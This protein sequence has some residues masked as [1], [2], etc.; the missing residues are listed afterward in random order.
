MSPVSRFRPFIRLST[1]WLVVALTC[2]APVAAQPAGGPDEAT[3]AEARRLGYEGLSAFDARRWAEAY[4]RF[5]AAE[6]L[7]HSPVFVLYMARAKL[8][9]GDLIEASRLLSSVERAGSR[10][11]D[12][13]WQRAREDA[14]REQEALERRVPKL[15]V[16][17]DGEVGEHELQ[18]DGAAAK[19]GATLRL[20]PGKHTVTLQVGDTR[21]VETVELV[22]AE[23]TR[24]LTLKLFQGSSPP[25]PAGET[26]PGPLAG[27]QRGSGDPGAASGVPTWLS[28]GI[29]GL[30]AV[31]L[32]VSGFSWLEA[33]D[34]ADAA[35]EGCVDK[36]C[37]KENESAKDDALFYAGVSTWT[38]V[39]GAALLVGGG[40]LWLTS[41][42][43]TQVGIAPRNVVLR[44]AF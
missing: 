27:P 33:S 4:E 30:G 42:S 10:G 6:E 29:M 36:V 23:G 8:Q 40:V 28:L 16:E 20:N 34:R 9:L 7:V 5:R 39:G 21:Y 41:D 26:R 35:K 19:L 24:Q 22:A 3:R 38:L 2:A 14:A 15:R 31:S 11:E 43:T 12:A 32:G 25:N 1:C 37:P 17:T 18:V 13:A 44:T